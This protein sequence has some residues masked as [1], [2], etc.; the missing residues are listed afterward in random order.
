[1][2]DFLIVG[3]DGEPIAFMDY[4]KMTADATRLMYQ[5][6]MTAGDDEATDQV[7]IEW[8]R[9]LDP[10]Y[11]GYVAAGALSLMVRCILA[12][13]L[14][15]TDELGVDLRKGLRDSATNAEA[16]LG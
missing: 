8:T 6:A 4:D 15:V 12:P 9:R 2:T 10:D 14:E 5:I 3:D 13:I 16:T 7:G 1:M 11:Y